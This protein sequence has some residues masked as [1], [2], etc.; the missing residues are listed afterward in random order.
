MVKSSEWNKLEAL[1]DRVGVRSVPS[2]F[3]YIID[4]HKRLQA[5]DAE[6]KALGDRLRALEKKW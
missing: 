5:L 6:N 4:L 1:Y 3:D 2:L